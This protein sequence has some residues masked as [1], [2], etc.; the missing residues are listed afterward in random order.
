M[1]QLKKKL[2]SSGK[3]NH[4][5]RAMIKNIRTAVQIIIV[6]RIWIKNHLNFS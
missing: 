1:N 2:I 4:L 6:N 5:F 3:I